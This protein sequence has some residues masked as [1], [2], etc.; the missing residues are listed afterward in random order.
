MLPIV[1]LEISTA[2]V[3]WDDGH[4]I[5]P[6]ISTILVIWLLDQ[7]PQDPGI[8]VCCRFVYSISFIES[9]TAS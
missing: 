7:L 2:L 9:R 8:P 6:A 4:T 1:R 5:L 3:T